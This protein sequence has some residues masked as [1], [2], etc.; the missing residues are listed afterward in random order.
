MSAT[1]HVSAPAT[2]FPWRWL[3]L[4]A[5]CLIP[6]FF[7]GCHLGGHDEDLLFSLPPRLSSSLP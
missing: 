4:A 3:A 7:H 6:I 2:F 1:L 5:I